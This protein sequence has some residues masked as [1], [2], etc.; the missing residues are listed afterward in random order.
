[1]TFYLA[2]S[3]GWKMTL[4]ALAGYPVIAFSQRIQQNQTN[5]SLQKPEEKNQVK[6]I[7]A[8]FDNCSSEMTSS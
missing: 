8:Y 1:M 4:V 7:F 5:D 6:I 3:T 2:F